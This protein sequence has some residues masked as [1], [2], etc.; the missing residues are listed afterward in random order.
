MLC[1][2]ITMYICFW[3]GGVDLLGNG[4]T[5]GVLGGLGPMSS[6]YFYEMLT[7]HTAAS[8]DQEHL[9]ILLSS[10]ADTPDRTSFILGQS[11][12]DPIPVMKF[13]VARLIGA[14]A[15]I[16]AIPC[17]TAHYFYDRISEES[18]VPIINIIRQTAI[19]C[20]RLGI[21]RAGIL[22]TEGTIASGAY[23]NVFAT[24]GMECICPNE[25]EQRIITDI[26]YGQIKQGK[27][28]D[29]DGFWKVVN[30]LRARGC[31]RIILG[32]T[33]LSLLKKNGELPDSVFIDS[34]E[35]LAYSA[36]KMCA[37]TPMGFSEEL[38]SFRT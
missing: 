35:V 27:E 24:A 23:S 21:K 37:K 34:L 33:E 15:D 4:K 13:E 5:L 6:V 2:I 17:N 8:C 26:I 7:A 18:G 20:Y 3:I 38:M 25:D 10:R 1:V 28:P 9:N 29:M 30:S 16:I 14:G 36:I 32:C 22:A 12:E 31:D 19:F 11:T